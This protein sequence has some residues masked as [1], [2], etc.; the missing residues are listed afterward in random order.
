MISSRM[1]LRTAIALAL[2]AGCFVLVFADRT[3]LLPALAPITAALYAWA[4]VLGA[5]ALLLG[6]GSVLWLHMR[7]IQSGQA[8]WWQSLALV[9]ALVAVF[10]AG[11]VNPAG[12]RSPLIEW[13][14]D[15]VLAPGY[16]A[17]YAS[18]VFFLGAA[19]YHLVRVGRRGGGW[20]LGGLLFMA[21]AQMPALRL[22]VPTAYADAAVWIVETP[23]SAS[24]RGVILGVALG[25]IVVAARYLAGRRR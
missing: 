18:M 4:V 15:S 2:I 7:R 1:P 8:G 25:L 10:V 17:L 20:V 14:F 12:A 22:I 23:V 9:G 19:I 6:A 21:F 5:F 11:I 24:V 13:T 16:G 3:G